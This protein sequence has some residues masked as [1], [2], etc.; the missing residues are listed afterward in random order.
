MEGSKMKLQTNLIKYREIYTYLNEETLPIALKDGHGD[1]VVGMLKEGLNRVAVGSILMA[2]GESLKA[3]YISLLWRY[4]KNEDPYIRESAYMGLNY[5]P[6][7]D[8]PQ[9]SYFLTQFKN[10]L[11]TEPS[12]GVR[13]QLEH[14]IEWMEDYL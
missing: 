8:R 2:L 10:N 9:Y 13:E 6:D 12:P 11:V 7:E 3:D 4:T 1:L 14:C 5:Y